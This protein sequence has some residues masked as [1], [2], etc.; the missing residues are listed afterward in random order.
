MKKIFNILFIFALS[1]LVMT[2]CEKEVSTED[3]SII[4]HYITFELEGP[5]EMVI[6]L[7]ESYEEPG[8]TAMEGETD[9]TGEVDIISTVNVN[10]AGVYSVVYEAVNEDGFASSVTRAVIV[11]DP[12]APDVDPSGTYDGNYIEGYFGQ[13]EIS[14]VAQGIFFCSD[15]FG[16]IYV[17]DFGYPAAYVAEGYIILHP[18]FSITSALATSPWGAEAITEG[19]YYPDNQKFVYKM[20]GYG[21][22]FTLVKQ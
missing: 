3:V 18:D 5:E 12:D 9:V 22:D 14:K 19:A 4:T 17:Y 1:L 6:P 2:S 16:G 8:Y 7:G 13:C 20:A 10:K 15:L 11:F 21:G